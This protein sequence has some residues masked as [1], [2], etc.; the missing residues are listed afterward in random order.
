[1]NMDP[2]IESKMYK[3]VKVKAVNPIYAIGVVWLVYGIAFPLYRI[4]DLVI[5]AAVSA[6]AY[7]CARK[8]LPERTL[9]TPLTD[10]GALDTRCMEL[11][12]RGYTYIAELEKYPARVNDKTITAQVGEITAISRQMFDYAAKNPR[13][14]TDLRNFV[15][16]YFPVTIKLLVTYIDMQTQTVKSENVIEIMAKVGTVMNKVTAAFHKHLDDMFSDKRLDVKTDIEVLKS[17]LKME[18]LGE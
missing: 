17:E 9:V 15:D 3:E 16:Y 13:I 10:K 6:L 4:T 8:F 14:A 12:T 11:I 5:A 1:M 18:G 7:I 2:K